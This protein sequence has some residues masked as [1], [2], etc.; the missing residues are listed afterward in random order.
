MMASFH[1]SL[2]LLEVSSSSTVDF[3]NSTWMHGIDGQR[4]LH[5]EFVQSLEKK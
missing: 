2:P 5:Q 1:D 4:I 3:W